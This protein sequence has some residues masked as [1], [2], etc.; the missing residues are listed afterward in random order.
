VKT[1]DIGNEKIELLRL[2]NP[3]GRSEW[4]GA[5][6]DQSS[7]WRSIPESTKKEMGLEV[8][9]DGEFWMTF[10]DFKKYFTQ[11]EMCH[12]SPD[13]IVKDA[14]QSHKN[15]KIQTFEGEWVKGVSAGGCRNYVDTFWLNPQYVV[16]LKEPDVGDQE[17]LCTVVVSLMQKNRRIRKNAEIG[18]L[19]MGFAIYKVTDAQLKEKPMKKDFFLYNMSVAQAPTFVNIREITCRFRFEP[20]NYLIIPSTFYEGQ[21]GEFLIRIFSES[22]NEL[23]EN[24]LE[25]GAGE[26]DHR[27]LVIPDPADRS[28]MEK[29]FLEVAGDDR[30]VD[31]MELQT[32]LNQCMK[33][34]EDSW[35]NDQ[36]LINSLF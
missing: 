35:S 1:F 23:Q 36:S 25:W 16:S 7:E 17:G 10:A 11:V 13:L 22:H 20:G 14:K 9:E 19:H 29:L 6:S 30:E 2:R 26:V 28:A 33:D 12:L 24:D 5:Y 34:G 15:W 18:F 32:I 27:V 21:V 3:W 4:N 8:K 31:W